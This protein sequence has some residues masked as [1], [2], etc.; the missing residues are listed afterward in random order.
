MV[1][2]SQV[3]SIYGQKEWL[4]RDDKER[5]LIVLSSEPINNTARMVLSQS[6]DNYE[7]E[8]KI[9]HFHSTECPP[10]RTV[11]AGGSREFTDMVGKRFGRFTVIGASIKKPKRGH[12]LWACKCSCGIYEHRTTHSVKNI[13][14]FMDMCH[15]CRHEITIKKREYF[16]TNGNY[17][18]KD[19]ELDFEKELARRMGILN[20]HC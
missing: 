9:S 8:L 1:Q 20:R 2:I 10:L 17:P 16:I 18:E 3:D 6:K 12:I 14:N 5:S 4:M 19:K 13:N 7:A 15:R 11:Y